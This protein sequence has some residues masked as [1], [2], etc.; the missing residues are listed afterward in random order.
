MIDDIGNE[1]NYTGAFF[2]CSVDKSQHPAD[3][4]QPL[5]TIAESKQ[6]VIARVR[7]Q[8]VLVHDCHSGSRHGSAV[9]AGRLAAQAQ[10]GAARLAALAGRDRAAAERELALEARILLHIAVQHLGAKAILRARRSAGDE[11]EAAP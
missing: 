3:A 5:E 1:V 8:I 7:A 4:A 10:L 2:K 9:T 6:A 11:L